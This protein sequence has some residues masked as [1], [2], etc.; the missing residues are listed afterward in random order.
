[1]DRQQSAPFDCSTIFEFLKPVLLCQVAGELRPLLVAA[2]W[3]PLF[4]DLTL[5]R[6]LILEIASG[7]T[8]LEQCWQFSVSCGKDQRQRGHF[9]ILQRLFCPV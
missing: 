3:A 4:H 5:I 7:D 1:M 8:I 6:E 2:H 9:K